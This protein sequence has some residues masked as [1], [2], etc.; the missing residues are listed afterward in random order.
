MK[1]VKLIISAIGPYAGELPPIEF[2]DFEEKGL[3]L[4]AGKTKVLNETHN[5]AH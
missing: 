2:G 5:F 3:F 4:I 1:P